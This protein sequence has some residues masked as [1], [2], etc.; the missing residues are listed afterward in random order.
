MQ[1]LVIKKHQYDSFANAHI[2]AYQKDG[3]VYFYNVEADDRVPF[4]KET[5]EIFN[6]K[7]DP[8]G[9]FMYYTVVRNG[10]L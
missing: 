6:L 4:T 8:D 3:Q 2:V 5:E 9:H 10:V 7:F 1:V